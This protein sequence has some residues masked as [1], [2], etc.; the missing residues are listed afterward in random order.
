MTMRDEDDERHRTHP[1]SKLTTM[2]HWKSY[3]TKNTIAN[4]GGLWHVS[5]LALSVLAFFIFVAGSGFVLCPHW[6]EFEELD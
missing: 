3:T 6:N 1:V 4:D 2:T 5:T